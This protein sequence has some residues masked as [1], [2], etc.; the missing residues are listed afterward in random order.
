MKLLEKILLPTKF[1]SVCRDTLQMAI[2]TA[3]IFNSEIILMFV[4]PE[5]ISSKL[6]RDM[7]NKN[8]RTQLEVFKNEIVENGVRT[9]EPILVSGSPF[10]QIIKQSNYLDVNVIM[11]G[12]GEKEANEIYP[13]GI[14]AE[15]VIR[16]S[17]K[18]VWLVKPGTLPKI[19]EI[20]CPVDFSDTSRRALK[21]AIHL[22]RNFNASLTVSTIIQ[23]LKGLLFGIGEVSD[24][25][26][27]SYERQH[28]DKFE[29]FLKDFDF[30]K[31]NWNKQIHKGKPHQEILRHIRKKKVDL[32]IMGSIGKTG[33]GTILLGRVAEKVFREVPC[34]AIAFKAESAI[35]LL[36][37]TKID[38]LE[39]HFELGQELLENGLPEDAIR[40]FMQCIDENILYVPAWEGLS[41]AYTHIGKGEQAERCRIEAKEIRQRL[42]E[43][44]VEA[45]I[46]SQHELFRRK[47][48]E[49]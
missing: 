2:R 28:Q 44:R 27:E 37:E 10:D 24:K 48:G 3:K 43:R 15:K 4:I 33:L 46:R 49:Y 41:K 26:Q 47:K 36:I 38:S 23:P 40:Q 30:H 7:L 29:R 17:N 32:L 25:E 20:L 1:S 13:L 19:M 35:N 18:P 11:M 31:V 14:T 9:C 34:S 12:A 21:N 45:E 5:K 42:W 8:A 6:V 39:K 16:K 22:A